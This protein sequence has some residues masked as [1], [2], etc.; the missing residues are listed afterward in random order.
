MQKLVKVTIFIFLLLVLGVFLG[1]IF[2]EGTPE[3]YHYYQADR[4]KVAVQS[5]IYNDTQNTVFIEAKSFQKDIIL[6]Q[7]IIK[8]FNG[9]VVVAVRM[10]D[11]ILE[12]QS[13]MVTVNINKTLATGP[14]TATFVTKAGSSFVSPPFNVP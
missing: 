8:D 10:S 6:T 1:Y 9:N 7:V 13:K 3:K 11:S 4:E 2:Y 5:P 12:G 14:H